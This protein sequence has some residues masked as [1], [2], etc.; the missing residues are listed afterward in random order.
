MDGGG[1]VQITFDGQLL[2]LVKE[3]KDG[4]ELDVYIFHDIDE[5]VNVAENVLPLLVG[6]QSNDEVDIAS[7]E[8]ENRSLNEDVNS[9]ETDLP[10]SESDLN[11]NDILD[12]DDSDIDEELRAF[13]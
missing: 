3:L 8:N 6:P 5:D 2:E 11:G 1:L 13:R 12:E 7:D 10:S 9:D 4:D